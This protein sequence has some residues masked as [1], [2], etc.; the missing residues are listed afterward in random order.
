MK[1][2]RITEEQAKLLNNAPKS[3]KK[4]QITSEQL[5]I[6][7]NTD[8]QELIRPSGKVIT[9]NELVESTLNE[10]IIMSLIDFIQMMLTHLGDFFTDPTSNGLSDILVKMGVSRG[11]LF[12]LMADLG[13]LTYSGGKVVKLW[14]NK[15]DLLAKLK[16]LY[17]K[18]KNGVHDMATEKDIPF[19]E[20]VVK[21]Y[22]GAGASGDGG[23]SGPFVTKAEFKET[24]EVIRR[25]IGEGKDN[26]GDP[27]NLKADGKTAKKVSK[28]D[29]KY[30]DSTNS[31]RS[32]GTCKSYSDG[33]CKFVRGPIT[34]DSVCDIYE[35]KITKEGISIKLTNKQIKLLEATDFG[36]NTT[37]K[38]GGFVHIDDCTKLN[39]NK[40]AIN[41]GCGAGDDGVVT[42]DSK[43]Q[44]IYSETARLTGKSIDE[45]KSIIKKKWVN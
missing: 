41:G 37:W 43:P 40:T 32:C 29:A 21:E 8:I 26:W 36:N 14:K 27:K 33:K 2:I 19:D 34:K 5:K 15:K 3:K 39:N 4:V 28:K 30:R 11:E 10:S 45:I 38:G 22:T 23:S 31:I 25:K 1:K 24:D 16:R 12:S 44:D 13:I 6:L 20:E 18:L 9:A 17:N 7:A 42:T 35:K